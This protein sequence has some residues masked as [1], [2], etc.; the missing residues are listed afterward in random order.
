M[1]CPTGSGYVE[2]RRSWWSVGSACRSPQRRAATATGAATIAEADQRPGEHGE[3]TS[4]L[5][6]GDLG[7]YPPLVPRGLSLHPAE[8]PS[9][10]LILRVRVVG[11][12]GRG[13]LDL[14]L[15]RIARNR[16]DDGLPILYELR[17]RCEL[18]RGEE[19]VAAVDRLL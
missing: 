3:P 10:E 17:H 11:V 5:R 12:K 4:A 14:P 13:R 7:E 9:A 6:R 2:V 15:R 19:A 1:R 16:R 18:L 8:R